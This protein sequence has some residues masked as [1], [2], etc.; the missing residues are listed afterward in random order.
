MRVRDLMDH[1]REIGDWVDWT[2]TNDVVLHGSEDT[3]VESIAVGWIASEKAARKAADR[4]ANVFVSHEGLYLDHPHAPE[5]MREV[6]AARCALYDD[7]GLTVVRCHDTWD[8]MPV[9][10]IPGAWATW[11][12]FETEDHDAVETDLGDRRAYYEVCLT[13]GIALERLASRIATR[14]REL[15]QS[16]VFVVGE[17]MRFVERLAVGTGAITRLHEM[18]Q[19][20]PDAIVMTDDGNNWTRDVLYAEGVDVPLICVAHPT[21]ELPGMMRLAEYLDEQL[22]DIPVRYQPIDYPRTVSRL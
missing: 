5:S 9:I 8:R 16:S 15:G 18:M 6:L 22:P 3:K 21:S 11:L 14:C 19:L 17:G 4:G 1:F 7:L 13:G 20:E 10:G 12:G 2:D